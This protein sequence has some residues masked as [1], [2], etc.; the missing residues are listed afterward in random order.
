MNKECKRVIRE[1]EYNSRTFASKFIHVLYKLEILKP[2][3]T[4]Y[5]MPRDD[6][7]RQAMLAG[8]ISWDC[9][10]KAEKLAKYNQGRIQRIKFWGSVVN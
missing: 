10:D 6:S 3:L 8:Q 2:R 9:R 7:Q 4:N 1:I 5:A